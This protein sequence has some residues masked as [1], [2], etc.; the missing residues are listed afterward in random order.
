MDLAEKRLRLNSLAK[1]SSS[2]EQFLQRVVKKM[3]TLFHAEVCSIY[4]YK[5]QEQKLTLT[6]NYG[7]NPRFINRLHIPIKVGLVGK[8]MDQLQPIID[9]KG[10]QRKEFLSIKN[11]G[12]EE[13]NAYLVVPLVYYQEKIGVF[14]MQRKEKKSFSKFELAKVQAILK[15]IVHLLEEAHALIEFR[16]IK[17]KKL[18][19]THKKHTFDVSGRIISKSTSNYIEGPA[20]W[21]DQEKN[22]EQSLMLFLEQEES[23][24]KFSQQK[25][26]KRFEDA[27]QKTLKQ[28]YKMQRGLYDQL[29]E[30]ARDIFVGHLLMLND[31]AYVGKIR[32]KITAGLPPIT[33]VYQVTKFHERIFSQSDLPSIREK[34]LD[35]REVSQRLSLNL[36][37]SR[38]RK[39]KKLANSIAITQELVPSQLLYLAY[40]KVAA[41]ILSKRSNPESHVALIAKSLSMPLLSLPTKEISE[42]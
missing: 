15:T 5:K 16:K 9:S 35:L 14:L 30:L 11:L 25:N 20:V 39:K 23:N 22:I 2:I 17:E 29:N 6:A 19:I 28:I 34:I 24:K 7:L 36:K 40:Q 38:T 21:L 13:Y 3:A 41:I 18:T 10:S 12:E 1:E 32:K 8:V 42:I 26:L 33:A 27:L 31:E 37:D 4:L